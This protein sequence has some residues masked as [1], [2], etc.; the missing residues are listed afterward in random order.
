MNAAQ[1]YVASSCERAA[2]SDEESSQLSVD[3]DELWVSVALANY[4]N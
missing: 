3:Q 4:P 2:M 1:Q